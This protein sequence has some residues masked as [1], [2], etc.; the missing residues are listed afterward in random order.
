MRTSDDITVI[1]R[2]YAE[3]Y[4]KYANLRKS[5]RYTEANITLHETIAHVEAN[6]EALDK[7]GDVVRILRCTEWMLKYEEGRFYQR[8][9]LSYFLREAA[10]CSTPSVCIGRPCKGF[11]PLACFSVH[12]GLSTRQAQCRPSAIMGHK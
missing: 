2:K 7:E 12:K 9:N 8:S 3:L 10:S 4:N 1:K 11:D 6:Q 5:R